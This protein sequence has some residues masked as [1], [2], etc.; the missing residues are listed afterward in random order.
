MKIR[1]AIIVALAALGGA[2]LSAAP[3]S[4]M[5]VAP[6]GSGASNIEN[7]AVVCGARGCVRAVPAY[8]RG[9]VVVR[10]PYARGGYYRRGYRRY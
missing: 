1:F 5:P 6:L 10:R 3:A 9:A 2:A 4:A 7:V 8:R